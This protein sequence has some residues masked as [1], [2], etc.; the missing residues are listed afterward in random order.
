MKKAKRLTKKERKALAPAPAKDT[1]APH[2]HCV[3]CGRHI[4]PDD[5]SRSPIRANWLRCAHGTKYASCSGCVTQ[6]M[7]RLA[8]HDRTGTP[9][10][11]A[12]AWH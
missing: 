8:D 9:V 6:S 11:A 1:N 2:I 12:A 5:F 7:Q 3:G 10:Q 4:S